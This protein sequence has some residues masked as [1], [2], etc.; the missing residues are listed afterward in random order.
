MNASKGLTVL[1]CCLAIL[2]TAR[3]ALADPPPTP[4]QDPTFTVKSGVNYMA[5]SQ[6]ETKLERTDVFAGVGYRPHPLFEL[7]LSLHVGNTDVK[8]QLDRPQ[9][10]LVFDGALHQHHEPWINPGINVRLLRTPKFKL[11]LFS[12]LEMPLSQN[13]PME[14]R[15]AHISTPQLGDVDATDFFM[16]HVQTSY[17]WYS[18]SLGTTAKLRLGALEPRLDIGVR[19]FQGGIDLKLDR[20]SQ[21]ILRLL[22][23]QDI[24]KTSYS[25]DYFTP[26]A[27]A[28]ADYHIGD[29][30]TA[31]ATGM[32]FPTSSGWLFGAGGSLA[33]HW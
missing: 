23:Y 33:A 11:D 12:D 25:M 14:I 15:A 26:M 31:T 10:K 19:R 18:F 30:F 20:Q 27:S 29:H 28:G 24:L 7:T 8:Y 6:D 4:R 5:G 13:K 21:S 32:A 2:L 22:G 9:D 1:L 16:D 17:R 3:P